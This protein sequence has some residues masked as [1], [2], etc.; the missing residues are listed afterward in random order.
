[1]TKARSSASVFS[2]KP[3]WGCASRMTGV[4]GVVRHPV[5]KSRMIEKPIA[6]NKA[7]LS[8]WVL[9]LKA[10]DPVLIGPEFGT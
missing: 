9:G 5:S 4:G 1:M 8:S 7:L 6:P 3:G 2:Q 10:I